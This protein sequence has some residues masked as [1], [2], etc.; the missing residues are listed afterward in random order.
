MMM[1][2]V[3]RY[4]APYPVDERTLLVSHAPF[5]KGGPRDY[6]LYLFDLNS[7]AMTLVYDDPAAAEVDAVARHDAGTC[8]SP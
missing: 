5:F 8:A 1:N 3:G 2:P 7:R 4:T 6:A